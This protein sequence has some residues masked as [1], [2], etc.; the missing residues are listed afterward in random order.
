MRCGV[1]RSVAITV[2]EGQPR[3]A[4]GVNEASAAKRPILPPGFLETDH[5]VFGIQTRTLRQTAED[6]GQDLLLHFDA[7]A[8]REEYFN[9]DEILRPAG[10]EIRVFRVKT[11]VVRAELQHALKPVL[12]GHA[13][14]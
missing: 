8:H 10:A 6:V 2:S 11:E 1:T 5:Q 12:L 4:S 7:A 13:L 14:R 9:Q 3:C